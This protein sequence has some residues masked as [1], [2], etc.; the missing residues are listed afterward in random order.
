MNFMWFPG[1][2]NRLNP[3]QLVSLR[4][5]EMSRLISPLG[6]ETETSLMCAEPHWVETS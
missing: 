6:D 2:S 3:S 5:C 1:Q 4:K